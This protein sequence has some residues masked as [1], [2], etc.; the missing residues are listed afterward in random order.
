MNTDLFLGSENGVDI[1]HFYV[2]YLNGVQ[3]P[4]I[5]VISKTASMQAPPALPRLPI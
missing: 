5:K 2:E 3:F 1:S 4:P